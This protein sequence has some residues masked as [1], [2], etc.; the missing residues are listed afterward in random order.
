MKPSMDYKDY[1]KQHKWLQ[2]ATAALNALTE[3]LQEDGIIELDSTG[4]WVLTEEAKGK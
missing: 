2:K 3:S 4:K 1:E